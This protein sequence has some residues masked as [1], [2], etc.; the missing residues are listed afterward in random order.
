MSTSDERVP[1][2]PVAKATAAS[3]PPK[4]DTT[5]EAANEAAEHHATEGVRDEFR[6]IRSDED[7][8]KIASQARPFLQGVIF[9]AAMVVDP[10]LGATYGVYK[11][12]RFVQGVRDRRRQA[13][14]TQTEESSTAS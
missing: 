7:V 10:V 3:E 1:G 2:K 6:A 14:I 4:T 5:S 13:K 8:Q 12:G 9:T 11:G